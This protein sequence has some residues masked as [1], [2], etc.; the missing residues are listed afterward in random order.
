MMR[1]LPSRRCFLVFGPRTPPRYSMEQRGR[2]H[3]PASVRSSTILGRQAIRSIPIRW[4]GVVS[5]ELRVGVWV[6][7]VGDAVRL[8]LEP[9]AL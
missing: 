8:G 6:S 3:P 7:L 1:F 2:L 4:K 5:C 9:A